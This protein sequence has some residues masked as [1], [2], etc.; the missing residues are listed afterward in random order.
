MVMF[1]KV[2]FTPDMTL[3]GLAR[4]CGVAPCQILAANGCG[5]AELAGR[6]IS[7]PVSTPHMVR[8]AGAVFY[9]PTAGEQADAIAEKFYLPKV[10]AEEIFEKSTQKGLHKGRILKIEH[11]GFAVHMVKPMQTL[12]SIATLYNTTADKIKVFNNIEVCYLGQKIYVP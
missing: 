3:L 5:E 1:I 6:M 12:A 9:Q 2:K 7:V 4:L 10:R 11:P 8:R